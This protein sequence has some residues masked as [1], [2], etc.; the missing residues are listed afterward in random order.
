[1]SDDPKYGYGVKSLS[2][3]K[4]VARRVVDVLGGGDNAYNL[5]IETAAA[6]TLC[7]L[8]PDVHP[9]RLGVGVCQCDE[10]AL[11]DIQMHLKD[12][13]AKAIGRAFGFEVRELA[14]EDLALDPIKSMVVARLHYLRKPPPIPATLA[15]R[16][17]YWKDQYN[18]EA[19]DGDASDYL[20][21]VAHVLPSHLTGGAAWQV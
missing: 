8:Y 10:I 9:F 21:R 2:Q 4:A 3:L 5:L 14:L 19:G 1:M 13:H 7:G 18:S 17:Q 15:E 16:A 12:R 11:K 6:E 20:E